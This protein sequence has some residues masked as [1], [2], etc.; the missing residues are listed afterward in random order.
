[1]KLGKG[2]YEQMKESNTYIY[3]GNFDKE[4]IEELLNEIVQIGYATNFK[5]EK[6][7]RIQI[8]E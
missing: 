5:V 7:N 4:R 8:I 2:L 3:D 6:V 1:M